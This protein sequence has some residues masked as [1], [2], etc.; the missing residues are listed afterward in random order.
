MHQNRKNLVP[1]AIYVISPDD[2]MSRLYRVTFVVYS[3]IL[4]D[5]Y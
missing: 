2:S 3:I 1:I 5:R 4:A